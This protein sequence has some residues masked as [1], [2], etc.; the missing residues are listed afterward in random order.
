MC[1]STSG[2]TLCGLVLALLSGCAQ[3]TTHGTIQG[4]VTLDGTPL[5]EGVVRFVPVDGA[6]QTAS[7]NVVAGEF[8]ALVPVGKM[9]VELSAPKVIG[10]QKMY[11]TADSP[12]VDVVS[13]L[14]PARYNVRSE[15]TLEVVAGTQPYVLELTSN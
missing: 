9:R 6:T 2:F 13:E 10:R 11:N 14:L 3:S 8:N 1:I 15:L 7:A 12:E 5:N 4:T